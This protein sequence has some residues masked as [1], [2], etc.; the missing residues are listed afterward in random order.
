MLKYSSKLELMKWWVDPEFKVTKAK[1]LLN[2]EKE[3][4]QIFSWNKLNNKQN[5]TKELRKISAK[6]NYF[7][8]FKAA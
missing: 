8:C 7:I 1:I 2:S 3:W 6:N 5:L 4:T